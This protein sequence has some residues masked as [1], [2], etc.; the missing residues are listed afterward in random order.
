MGKGTSISVHHVTRVEGH[1]NIVVDLKD[2]TLQRCELQIVESPRFFE[3]L[4]KDRPHEEA[5]R[6]TCRICGICS[7]G[8]ATASIQAVEAALG[9]SPGPKTRALRRLNMCG[10]WLQSHVLHAYFLVAPDLFQA[11]SVIP[12]ASS[13]P[14]IVKRALRLKGLANEICYAISGR[15]VMP[16]SYVPG[17]MGHWPSAAGLETLRARLLA[18]KADIEATVEL[19]AS[20]EWPA[21]EQSIEALAALEEDGA[22]P[23]MGGPIHSSRGPVFAPGAYREASAEHLVEHSAAKHTRGAHG[24]VRVG[25]LARYQL[26]HG[27]L[28]RAAGKAA[29]ALKLAPDSQNPFHTTP[30]QVVEAVQAWEEAIALCERLLGD[31]TPEARAPV[32]RPRGGSGVGLAEVPRGL[33]I[34]DY[35]VGSDGRIVRANC[36]IPTGQNLAAVEADMRAFVPTLLDRPKEQITRLMEMLV[37]A[38]DPCIS[39]AV[40][41]LDVSFVDGDRAG[42]E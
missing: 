33:L 34:H 19:F 2:G 1:G 23:M 40:H 6:I 39:C 25:A 36:V 9:V 15:H 35:E 31:P 13:H 12:L 20:V 4:L 38:Y 29:A 37:R 41:L 21:F 26:A 5:P 24:P 11:P 27:R 42:A 16:I 7:V 8:H 18:A 32:T 14:E 22:Y 17:G 28:G 3:A 10:E 30:A